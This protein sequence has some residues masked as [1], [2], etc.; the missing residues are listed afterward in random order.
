MIS[1]TRTGRLA[2]RL[3]DSAHEI[4]SGVAQSIGGDNEGLSP[5]HLLEA[6]LAACTIIT[7]QMYANRKGWKL[8]KTDVVV[9]ITSEGK[10]GTT[11]SRTIKFTGDLSGEERE[12]LMDIANKCPIHKLLSGPVTIETRPAAE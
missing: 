8:E 1:G 10:D 6:A 5:H 11:L 9:E 12:R 7:V 4:V 2:A 3:T